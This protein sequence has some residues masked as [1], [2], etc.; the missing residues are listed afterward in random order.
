MATPDRTMEPTQPPPQSGARPWSRRP[1]SLLV[2]PVL[3]VVGDAVAIVLSIIVA[4]ALRQHFGL[5]TNVPNISR[6]IKT[7]APIILVIW[8]VLLALFSAY[9]RDLMGV[10]TEEYQR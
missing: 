7:A 3:L 5:Y 10:G 9:K 6:T 1:G 4:L 2:A 8:L